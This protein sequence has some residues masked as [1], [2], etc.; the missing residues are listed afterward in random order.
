M[1]IVTCFSYF[2]IRRVGMAI[3]FIGYTVGQI[4]L[5]IDAYEMGSGSDSS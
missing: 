1:Y 2:R 5:I 3:A 4:G